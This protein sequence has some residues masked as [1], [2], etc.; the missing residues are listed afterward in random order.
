MI[1]AISQVR[2]VREADVIGMAEAAAKALKSA[3]NEIV[4]S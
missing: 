4:I 1:S 3:T 2:L